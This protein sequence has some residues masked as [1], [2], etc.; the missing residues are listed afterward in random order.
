MQVAR[1]RK[2]LVYDI[3]ESSP[4]YI[5]YNKQQDR[6]RRRRGEKDGPRRDDRRRA[7]R[8]RP[9]HA[10]G[11][12]VPMVRVGQSDR[13][14]ADRARDRHDEQHRSEKVVQVADQTEPENGRRPVFVAAARAARRRRGRLQWR[15]R[16]RPCSGDGRRRL[17]WRRRIHGH[18]GGRIRPERIQVSTRHS[19]ITV[20]AL[21]GA[22]ADLFD[23][24]SV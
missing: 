19:L 2:W 14:A 3:C 9:A 18:R 24:L 17:K 5:L 15:Q 12:Q 6:S 23:D 1:R 7:L 16:W 20:S 10:R 21:V 13:Q 4:R 11:A 22:C 8:A